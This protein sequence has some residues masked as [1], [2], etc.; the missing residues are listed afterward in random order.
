MLLLF[1]ANWVILSQKNQQQQKKIT[2]FG[3]GGSHF[4]A[5]FRP[6]GAKLRFFRNKRFSPVVSLYWPNF[7]PKISKVSWPNSEKTLKNLKNFIFDPFYP[8]FG[9]LGFFSKNRFPSLFS[10]YGPLTSCKKSEKSLEPIL[11]KTPD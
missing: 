10:I 2:I 1:F 4:W 7:L 9:I 11:R 5:I 8:K 6:P 3:S